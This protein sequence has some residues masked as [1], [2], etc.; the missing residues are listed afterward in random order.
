MIY[1]YDQITDD[2]DIGGKARALADLELADFLIPKWCVLTPQ[3]FYQSLP[4]A[5]ADSWQVQ[6]SNLSYTEIQAALLQLEIN[7]GLN[8]QLQ[9]AMARLCPNGERVA[10]RSSALDEDGAE[11]SF[12]GQ[13]DSV[14][15][16][17]QKQLAQRIIQVWRSG[18]SERI[19]TYRKENGLSLP[20]PPPAVIVQQMIDAQKAGVAFSA[21]PVSGRRSVSVVGAVYG[22]GSGLVSGEV[23]ADTYYVNRAEE[24]I[25]CEIANKTRAHAI[26]IDE[27]EGVTLI[28]IDDDMAG[29][30]VLTDQDVKEIARIVR[31]CQQHF[32]TPQDIEWAIADKKIYLLQSRPITSLQSMTDPDANL[33]IWDNS[34][35]AESYRGVTTPLTF[36]F[37][38][39]AYASVYREF[40]HMM[41]VPKKVVAQNDDLFERMLGLINGQVYYN[42]ISWYRVLALLPGFS[43]NRKFMEQMMG[44]KEA[45]PSEVIDKWVKPASKLD[46]VRDALRLVSTVSGLVVNHFLMPLKIRRFYK[47]LNVAMSDPQVPLQ[48]QRPDELVEYY[49]DLERQ[50]LKRWDAPLVNDFFAMIFYGVLRKLAEK[51]CEDTDGT[52]Q[53]DL[54]VGEGDIISAE[55]AKRIRKMAEMIFLYPE[56]I[57][58]LTQGSVRDIYRRLPN[59]KEFCKEYYAYLEKFGDRCLDELKLESATL[60]DNP[61]PVLR[62]IGHMAKRLQQQ[63]EKQHND[64]N[65]RRAAEKHVHELLSGNKI[66]RLI[67]KWILKHARSR[68]SNRENLRFERTRLFGRVR[69]IF[70]EI[71]HRF[72]DLGILEQPRDIFYLEV[73]EIVGYVEGTSTTLNLAELVSIRQKEFRAYSN[74]AAPSDRFNTRGTVYHG[75]DFQSRHENLPV[76]GD[77]LNGIGCCPGIVRGRVRVVSDPVGVELHQGEILV[78]ER[79]DP[80]WIML[81]PAAAGLLVEHGSLLSHSAIVAR[82]MGIPA[83]V[84]L[85]GVTQWLKDG[86]WVEMNGRLGSVRKINDEVVSES[87][88][89]M[90]DSIE[91]KFKDRFYNPE[92]A[93]Q[94]E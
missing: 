84:S 47:R 8:Q 43:M 31:R 42:L 66:R 59:Y 78:A 88:I 74:S 67:F 32:H 44:V 24:I 18:F 10:V 83:V 55:P 75:H 94:V 82:E 17:D 72:Y 85:D 70:L 89:E 87:P 92:Q 62:S 27:V 36:S 23:D 38:R 1:F 35:I 86:D 57:E 93:E 41:R 2:L 54:L 9:T 13:L 40:C 77:E 3:A 76:E 26:G 11:H 51:W 81:F 22:L 61:L 64:H 63:P 69:N 52:L 19:Y 50:L 90:E 25:N 4:P 58:L 71:G 49:H 29:Q 34:N 5:Y 48:Q 79:T 28:D 56:L 91:D 65:Q 73:G 39:R 80:G 16:V 14:L 53:N 12:A 15:F 46:K 45:M 37:A 6:G 33:A 68:V 30:S 21:D 60:H 7:A 20:P